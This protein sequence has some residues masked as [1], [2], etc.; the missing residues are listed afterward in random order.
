MTD[1][2][3]YALARLADC[4]EPDSPDSPG[5]QWLRRLAEDAF[6]VLRDRSAEE[7]P[8]DVIHEIADAY[9]PVYTI[10]VWKIFVDL[11]AWEALQDAWDDG[12]ISGPPEHRDQHAQV[13]LYVIAERLLTALL[14]LDE[15]ESSQQQDLPSF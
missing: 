13:A 7:E 3:V 12:L 4:A 1:L 6:D 14:A 5:G 8:Q 2:T 11:G 15:C 9:V 10:D